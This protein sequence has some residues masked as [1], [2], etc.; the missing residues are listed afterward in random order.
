LTAVSDRLQ[1]GIA[2]IVALHLPAM[3][4]V[5]HAQLKS[6]LVGI[7]GYAKRVSAIWS[8]PAT[9]RT[10][11]MI[12]FPWIGLGLV[13]PSA[14]DQHA[15]WHLWQKAAFGLLAA[16][17]VSF[18]ILATMRVKLWGRYAATFQVSR[19]VLFDSVGRMCREAGISGWTDPRVYVLPDLSQAQRFASFGTTI[20]VPRP[21]LD[22]MSRRE[23][24]A[25]VARQ[26]CRQSKHYYYP[27]FWTLLVCD[28][29]AVGL[30]EWL[31]PSSVVRWVALLP[32]LAAQFAALAS[33][34]PRALAR[35][36]FRA[37]ELT[38]DPQ[39][40][41]SSMAGLARFTGAPMD[42]ASIREIARHGG[43]PAERIP[44]LLAERTVPAE[45]RYPTAG[46]YML[47]GLQ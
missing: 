15:P 29:A 8:G 4:F 17:L 3:L 7:L 1:E 32:V 39:A 24:D 9:D 31:A 44:D 35:A 20:L 43:V 11:Y 45:D 2:M 16:I 22:S 36:D 12:M 14:A 33:Y 30:L 18:A 42:E 27:P 19:G 28:V 23:M 46:P 38:G 37:A 21:L 34:L 5:D 6:R 40:F 41:L 13:W 26:L 25:L 10:F 47:T